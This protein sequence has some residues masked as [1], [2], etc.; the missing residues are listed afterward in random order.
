MKSEEITSKESE[1]AKKIEVLKGQKFIFK[2]DEVV[3]LKRKNGLQ[4]KP[5]LYLFNLSRMTYI[6]SLKEIENNL[7]KFDVRKGPKGIDVYTLKYDK[8][9]IEIE[10][11]G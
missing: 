10:K 2:N 1:S 9:K 7:Y 8:G 3:I 11:I 6:S 4:E 5:P